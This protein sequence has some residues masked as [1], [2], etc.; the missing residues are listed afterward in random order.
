M[1][2]MHMQT[3]LCLVVFRTPFLEHGFKV[4]YKLYIY[5]LRVS[6][7]LPYPKWKFWVRACPPPST[8]QYR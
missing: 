6:H 7:T 1:Y 4:K 5:I 2:I 8:F 3:A